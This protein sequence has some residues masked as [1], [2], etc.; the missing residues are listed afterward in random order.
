MAADV[1]P[2][3]NLA[4]HTGSYNIQPD[5]VRPGESAVQRAREGCFWLSLLRHNLHSNL[6]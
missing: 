1:I 2:G 6:R 3:L 4:R 5:S